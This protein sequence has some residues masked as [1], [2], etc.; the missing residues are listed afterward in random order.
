M[1][2]AFETDANLVRYL[3]HELP[4]LQMEKITQDVMESELLHY[5]LYALEQTIYD[6]DMNLTDDFDL[7]MNKLEEVAKERHQCMLRLIG[8][9]H[10]EFEKVCHDI[11]ELEMT[12]TKAIISENQKKTKKSLN[13]LVKKTKKYHGAMGKPARKF[14][15]Q[16]IPK[17]RRNCNQSRQLNVLP[18]KTNPHLLSTPNSNH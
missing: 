11:D 8:E 15:P 2:C 17:F 1:N 9:L 4:Y 3:R 6:L 10:D 7:I 13:W 16:I 5:R 14:K 12:M 18:M